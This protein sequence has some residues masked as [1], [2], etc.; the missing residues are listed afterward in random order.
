MDFIIVSKNLT[1]IIVSYTAELYNKE[2]FIFHGIP[3]RIIYN[4]DKK[5][6]SMMW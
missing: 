6:T 4:C 5:F 2:I 3:K 1:P